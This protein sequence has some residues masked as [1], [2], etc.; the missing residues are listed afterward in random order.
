MA[1]KAGAVVRNKRK[2]DDDDGDA[3]MLAALRKL[4]HDGGCTLKVLNE[5]VK[6]LK[7]FLKAKYQG[8]ITTCLKTVTST[9]PFKYN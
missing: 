4:Y 2:R 8:P 7:P 1:N 9:L 6:N 3:A 5:V